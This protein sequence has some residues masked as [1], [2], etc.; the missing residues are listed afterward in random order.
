[1]NFT[2]PP[3]RV[4]TFGVVTLLASE[5]VT[6]SLNES[7]EYKLR[8][9]IVKNKEPMV[10]PVKNYSDAVNVS[11]SMDVL[12]LTDLD[13]KRQMLLTNVLIVQRWHNPFLE[14]KKE[15]Y[16]GIDQIVVNPTEIWV[17]DIVLYNK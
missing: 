11:F 6:L 16:G 14:W 10:R 12:T 8:S 9:D 3:L 17:P 15:V 4:M 2:F 5:G 1:M 13:S 7:E